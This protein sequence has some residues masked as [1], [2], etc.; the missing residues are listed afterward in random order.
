MDFSEA[1]G[2]RNDDLGDGHAQIR[3]LL[4]VY[5][6]AIILEQQLSEEL[7]SVARH[8]E[9]C[10]GCRTELG[11]LLRQIE[12]LYNADLEP[13]NA[14]LALDLSFLPH[15]PQPPRVPAETHP[16]PQP[17]APIRR[18]ILVLNQQLE[19]LRKSWTA[20]D[21]PALLVSR[22]APLIDYEPSPE[23]TSGFSFSVQIY[24]PAP[25]QRLCDLQIA[26]VLPDR[27]EAPN[28]IA[29][30]LQVDDQRWEGLADEAGLFLFERAVSL[31]ATMVQ[32]A[33]EIL[34]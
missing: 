18:I 13:A 10:A 17:F 3:Q 2:Q 21:R 20:A 4:P 1:R 11:D 26:I 8:L 9:Q 5:A 27:I 12:P 6:T 25:G 15:D 22:G 7:L 24:P 19:A 23:S 34:L 16:H 31:Q 28:G 30:T 33:A 14:K 32:V 29:L